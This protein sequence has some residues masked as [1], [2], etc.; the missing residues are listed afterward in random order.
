MNN[1][2]NAFFDWCQ[3]NSWSI[4]RNNRRSINLCSSITTRY[5]N[6]PIEY[7]IFLEEFQSI[8]SPDQQ[9]WFLCEDD[10]NSISDSKFSWN[11]FEQLSLEAASGDDVWKQE[12]ALWWNN[13]FPIIISVCGIYSFYAID[14]NS[15]AIVKGTEPEFESTKKIA[16]NFKEFLDMVIYGE[17]KLF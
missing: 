3:Q 9:T 13:N 6:I 5:K 4:V 2:Y 17:I 12:I 16:A 11:E 14:M 10:Y 7:I 15:Q 8:I 1:L